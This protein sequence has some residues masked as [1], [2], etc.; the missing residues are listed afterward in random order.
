MVQVKDLLAANM[1]NIF[2][3]LLLF[4]ASSHASDATVGHDPTEPLSWLKPEP[5][6]KK[7]L[8]NASIFLHYKQSVVMVSRIVMP[9][10]MISQ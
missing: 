9:F 10:W 3:V 4:S 8:R 1:K 6:K 2:L 7:C 5:V